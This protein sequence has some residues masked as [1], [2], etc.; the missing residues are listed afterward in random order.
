MFSYSGHV[1]IIAAIHT[2]AWVYLLSCVHTAPLYL[3]FMPKHPQHHTQQS[4]S[5]SSPHHYIIVSQGEENFYKMEAYG[6]FMWLLFFFSSVC[7]RAYLICGT[8]K[9][10]CTF[11]WYD[12]R[13]IQI[14]QIYKVTV[15]CLRYRE[16][17]LHFVRLYFHYL[18]TIFIRFDNIELQKS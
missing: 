3:G 15:L 5:T 9:N 8:I 10:V 12:I 2:A 16:Q 6:V 17:F 4:S 18:L 7:V 11:W 14:V 1:L 13:R